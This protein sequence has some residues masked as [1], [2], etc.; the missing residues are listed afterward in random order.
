M[1][2]EHKKIIL[3]THHVE[4]VNVFVSDAQ[5]AEDTVLRV[6]KNPKITAD[7]EATYAKLPSI[8][9]QD[10]TIELKVYSR[11]LPDAP[12]HA[13]GFIGVA[14][15]INEEDAQFEAIY[16]RPTNGRCENQL[17]RNRSVQ[18]FSY[19][20]YK[21]DRLRMESPGEY[22]TYTD[23]GLEEWIEMKIE[24]LGNQAKLYLNHATQPTLIVNDLKHGANAKGAIGLWTDVGTEANFKDLVVRN[25]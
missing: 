10:G 15:R 12:T 21:F 22:E 14:F 2:K 17:R 13:R 8:E 11:L 24:V 18:Y 23:I 1:G 3:N 19:P 16:I 20:D 7:D 5:I 25:K 6:T 4:P 9:F